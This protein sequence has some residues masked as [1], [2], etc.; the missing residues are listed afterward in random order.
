MLL[1]WCAPPDDPDVSP[2]CTASGEPLPLPPGMLHLS[3]RQ[4]CPPLLHISASASAS[5]GCG[6][7]GQESKA[8]HHDKHLQS[9]RQTDS[10]ISVGCFL[11]HAASAAYFTPSKMS[12]QAA[13]GGRLSLF[14]C[15]LG[16][17]CTYVSCL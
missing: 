9:V 4:N 6:D 1:E 2:G 16:M 3:S 5:I 14:F 17:M 13:L 15:A 10:E 8:S 11:S 12:L 7:H